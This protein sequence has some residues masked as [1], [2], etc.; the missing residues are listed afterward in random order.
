MRCRRTVQGTVRSRSCSAT[1]QA[2]APSATIG[3]AARSGPSG[4]WRGAAPPTGGHVRRSTLR[5]AVVAVTAALALTACGGSSGGGSGSGT[6]ADAATATSAKAL[7][8]MDA[9]VKAAKKE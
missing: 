5:A 4:L 7:G 8:G 1:A 9:L 2:L 3:Q 6:T